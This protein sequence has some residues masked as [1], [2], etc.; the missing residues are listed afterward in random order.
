MRNCK[1]RNALGNPHLRACRKTSGKESKRCKLFKIITFTPSIQK[2]RQAIFWQCSDMRI[3]Y[4]NASIKVANQFPLQG[5]RGLF[6]F[7]RHWC[8]WQY[9]PACG[10]YPIW[11]SVCGPNP[12]QRPGQLHVQDP[13]HKHNKYIYKVGKFLV[14]I[15][16]QVNM[17][18]QHP[19]K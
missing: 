11:R 6:Y 13:K 16:K 3:H 1:G 8:G 14:K 4:W 12:R 2:I 17:M 18:Y 9:S 5:V 15:Q 7:L 19:E 10:V